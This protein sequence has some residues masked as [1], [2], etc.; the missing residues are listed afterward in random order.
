M[1]TIQGELKVNPALHL[2]NYVQVIARHVQ[3]IHMV[4]MV[5]NVNFAQNQHQLQMARLA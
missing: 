4:E 1:D 5:G 3:S 2:A